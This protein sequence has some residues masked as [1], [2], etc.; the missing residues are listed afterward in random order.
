MVVAALLKKPASYTHAQVL[1]VHKEEF[2]IKTFW[3]FFLVFA[4]KAPILAAWQ[5]R[6]VLYFI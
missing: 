2:G 3:G 4:A 6:S 1:H 5:L